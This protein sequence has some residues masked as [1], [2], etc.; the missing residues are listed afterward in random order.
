MGIFTHIYFEL[1]DSFRIFT[2]IYNQGHIFE[3]NVV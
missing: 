2:K 1:L 3:I